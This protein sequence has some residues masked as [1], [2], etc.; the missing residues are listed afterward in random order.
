MRLVSYARTMSGSRQ[1][2]DRSAQK[3]RTRQAIVAAAADLLRQ[4]QQP[5]V[6]AAAAAAGVHRATAYR[7]FPS[8]QS[9]LADAALR[10]ITP[11]F[12]R[13][14]SE[15]HFADADPADAAGLMDA[16]VRTMAEL[17]FT[18]EATFRNIVRATVDRW[19]AEQDRAE[20]DPEA[21]RQTHRF[22]WIDH[23]LTPLR[24]TLPP[25]QLHRL[26]H[27]LA[28]VFGAESLIV[29]RDVCRL[30]PQQATEIM[31]WAATTLIRAA[32]QPG[33]NSPP[34]HGQ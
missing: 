7:Y 21:I 22:E 10:T 29:T 25:S 8:A 31:R 11:D 34:D 28:L 4:G 18:E 15:G 26:R 12:G 16:A 24:G 20:P 27:A 6:A 2:P 23:A 19:F 30:Q 5:T 32:T 33:F 3:A 14:F 9:L 17:M 1:A 13:V